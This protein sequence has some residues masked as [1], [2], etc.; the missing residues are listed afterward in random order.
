M[1]SRY[2]QNL[3]ESIIF[4]MSNCIVMV[5]GMMAVNMF[6]AGVLTPLNFISGMGPIFLTAFFVSELI[7]G[8]I[9]HAITKKF[10]AYRYISFIRVAFMAA[11]MTFLVPLLQ[12][13]HIMGIGH[14]LVAFLLNY[15]AAFILQ[16]F[17][18]IR[19][20]IFVLGRVRTL[21]NVVRN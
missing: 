18:E 3:K 19:F 20:A 8:P 21:T 13:R 4:G 12:T 5:C 6:F 7:V 17:V 1:N 10:N 11:I 9:V 2:P 14:Y 16:V 15:I